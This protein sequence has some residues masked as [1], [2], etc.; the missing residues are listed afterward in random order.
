M[1]AVQAM[2]RHRLARVSYVG[3]PHAAVQMTRAQRQRQQRG[4][5][6]GWVYDGQEVY[7]ALAQ[8]QGQ[9]EMDEA[10]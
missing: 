2:A 6:G 1:A 8:F 4:D 3:V 5:A 9:H 7:A 10:A